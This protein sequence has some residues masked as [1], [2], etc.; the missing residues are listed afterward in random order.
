MTT[1]TTTKITENLAGQA[2]RLHLGVVDAKGPKALAVASAR[3]DGFCIGA[4]I[5]LSQLGAIDGSTPT[6]VLLDIIG[7]VGRVSDIPGPDSAFGRSEWAGKDI[8]DLKTK[9]AS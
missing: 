9:W 5:A 6:A 1:M 3:L 7:V 4:A 2:I 8:T